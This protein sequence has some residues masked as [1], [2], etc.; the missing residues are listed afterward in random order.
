[1][2]EAIV[3]MFVLLG[4]FT[5]IFRLFHTAMR[6]S[7]VIDAQQ[8]KVRVAQNKLEEIRAWSRQHHQP[9]GPTL[10]SDWS[11][12]DNTS[13]S[14]PDY[15]S[16]RWSVQVTPAALF[17]PCSL[18][19][20]A[21]TVPSR[22]RR[23]PDSCKQIVVTA[24]TGLGSPAVR[25]TTLIGQPSVDPVS[26]PCEVVVGGLPVTLT[27]KQDAEF[28]AALRTT[29]RQHQIL[30]V[31]FRWT[32]DPDSG[33]ATGT[34]SGPRTGR[35]TRIQ[36]L[37]SIP[38]SSGP[39]HVLYRVTEAN[40]VRETGSAGVATVGNPM[41]LATGLSGF[42]CWAEP[43]DLLVVVLTYPDRRVIQRLLGKVVCPGVGRNP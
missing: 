5:V 24:D 8:Q 17:S 35:T 41:I 27:H 11:A 10:F 4:G 30:D 43:G 42:K 37:I 31:F 13:G 36:H 40:L 34:F 16:I 6:Y 29:D 19:E 32:V 20:Q 25:L 1:M 15:P 18:F 23:M 22:R 9:I 33:P 14:D 26:T 12:W 39:Q 28:T 21:E 2:A 7:S 38:Q 3:A